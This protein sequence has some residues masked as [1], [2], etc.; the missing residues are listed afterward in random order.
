MNYYFY[1]LLSLIIGYV[2]GRLGHVFGGSIAWIPHHWI[3]GLI[4]MVVP[5]F[6]RKITKKTKILIILF[7]L[8]VFVSDL[9]DFL[10][11]KVF[12]PEDVYAVKFFG[13]D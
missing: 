9:K 11:L 3:F 12:E 5:L 4:I 6:S 7:G 13:V 2:I 1:Y 8:G 10:D